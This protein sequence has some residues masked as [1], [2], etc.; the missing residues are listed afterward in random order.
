MPVFGYS[1]P[2]VPHMLSQWLLNMSDRAILERFVSLDQLGLYSLSFQFALVLQVIAA[3][4]NNPLITLFG[5]S[6]DED[7]LLRKLPRISTYYVLVCTMIGVA[8]GLFAREV[9]VL[10]LP[11]IYEEVG[12]LV[13][14]IVVGYIVMTI[15]YISM[16]KLIMI[17]GKSRL[18]P[19]V[20]LIGGVTNVGMNILTVPKW[21][22]WAAAVNNLLGYVILTFLMYLA[23]CRFQSFRLELTRLG[24]IGLA[25]LITFGVGY[26]VMSF[27]PLLNFLLG[28]SLLLLFPLLLGLLRFW[29]KEEVSFVLRRL[30]DHQVIDRIGTVLGSSD[31]IT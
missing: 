2:F 22:I 1:L 29:S 11:E 28:L 8:I 25:C 3:S 13:R 30:G 4:L 12:Y 20:T 18:V 26:S 27:K 24:K 7:G 23:S 5:R 31:E 9:V 15:Y 10:F 6:A 16:N 17:N 21:G 14:W 19:I